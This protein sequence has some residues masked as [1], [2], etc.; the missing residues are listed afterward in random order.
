MTA[1]VRPLRRLRARLHLNPLFRTGALVLAPPPRICRYC[2]CDASLGLRLGCDGGK[3]QSGMSRSDYARSEPDL[4]SLACRPQG[5]V[6]AGTRGGDDSSI[7][8]YRT[9]RRRGPVDDGRMGKT[10]R[11]EGHA[12]SPG[13]RCYGPA[14]LQCGHINLTRKIG[15]PPVY[16]FRGMSIRSSCRWQE[17]VKEWHPFECNDPAILATLM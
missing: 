15:T 5:A 16:L 12:D 13:A 3:L 7:R 17:Q 8:R 9:R 6:L 2:R 10:Q 4:C 1:A 11:H 14:S